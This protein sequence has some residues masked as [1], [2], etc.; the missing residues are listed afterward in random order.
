MK[1]QYR[2]F[3]EQVRDNVTNLELFDGEYSDDWWYDLLEIIFSN[4]DDHDVENIKEW[5]EIE[6][7]YSDEYYEAEV[8]Y[9]HDKMEGICQ[10]Y[11]VELKGDKYTSEHERLEITW[12][13]DSEIWLMP[14]YCLGIQWWSMVGVSN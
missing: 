11:K 5:F 12:D 3:E 8:E 4:L 14:V 13:D 7:E 9:V 10:V 2:N 6:D 1:K